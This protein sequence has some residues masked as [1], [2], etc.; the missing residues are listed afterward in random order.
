MS[1]KIHSLY[2]YPVKGFSPER[3][4]FADLTAGGYFPCD[5]LYAVENGASG[6]DPEAPAFI[7]KTSFTVL[8]QIPKVAKAKTAYDDQSGIFSITAK[9]APAFEGNLQHEAG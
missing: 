8:A 5:R 2:R 9:G 4:V 7:S 3:L 1:G 6:F